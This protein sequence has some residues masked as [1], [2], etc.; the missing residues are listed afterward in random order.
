MLRAGIQLWE[1]IELMN[2]DPY[3]SEVYGLGFV[4]EPAA[5]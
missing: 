1:V 5:S 3:L 2:L 4:I